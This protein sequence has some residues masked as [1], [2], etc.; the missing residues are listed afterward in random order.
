MIEHYHEH[1]FVVVPGVLSAEE[2]LETRAGL[3]AHLL[4]RGVDVANLA[5]TGHLLAQLS[6]TGGAGGVL[7]VFWEPFKLRLLDHA[8]IAQ[9]GVLVGVGVGVGVGVYVALSGCVHSL[10]R[11]CAAC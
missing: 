9:V 7:D 4:S 11:T 10:S 5:D 6:S 8:G 1:G 2:V 3:H